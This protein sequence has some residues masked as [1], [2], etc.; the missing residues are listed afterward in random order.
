MTILSSTIPSRTDSHGP[1]VSAITTLLSATLIIDGVGFPGVGV[2][3]NSISTGLLVILA[4]TIRP[5]LTMPLW[6][7]ILAFAGVSWIALASV[8]VG[9]PD[10][11]RLTNLALISA[12]V[13]AIAS[14]RLDRTDLGRGLGLGVIVGVAL[15]V[16]TFQ[17]SSYAQRLTGLFGDPNTAGLIIAVFAALAFSAFQTRRIKVLIVAI[18]ATGIWLTDSRT[19]MLAAAAMLVWVLL[20][21]WGT[22]PWLAIVLLTMAFG[23]VFT[24]AQE[25]LGG[26]AF[27]ARHGS[28]Q[29][30]MRINDAELAQIAKSPWLGYG[31]GSARVLMDGMWFFFHSSYL[32]VRSEGGWIAFV[33]V[34]GLLAA[35]FTSLISLGRAR[36]ASYEA[37][38]IGVAICALNLGEVLMTIMS[39]L[40]MGFAMQHIASTRQS[41]GRHKAPPPLEALDEQLRRGYWT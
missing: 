23:W 5:R 37:A 16:A 15:G 39:A 34:V 6:M 40:A 9:N 4:I 41:R 13:P 32:S 26:A 21:K 18:A 1:I 12:L 31:A 22:N 2:P 7:P 30:R 36:N 29:L 38:I 33:L 14:G 35:T 11:K 17:Q 20:R 3:V 19:T 28:D 24:A 8:V 27:T 10:I 25:G